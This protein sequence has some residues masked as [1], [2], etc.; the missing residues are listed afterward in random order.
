[1][2]GSGIFVVSMLLDRADG[3][4][5]RWSGKTSPNG[6]KYDIIADSLSNALAFVG[7]GIGQ[8]HSQLGD[9]AIPL[10]LLQASRLLPFYGW[11]CGPRDKKVVEPPN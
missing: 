6:H 3:A 10:A 1:M 9:F 4:L 5:A 2:I 7:I 8:R 11:L